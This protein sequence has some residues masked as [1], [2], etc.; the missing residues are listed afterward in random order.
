MRAKEKGINSHAALEIKKERSIRLLMLSFSTA[1][2][3]NTK[4][5]QHPVSCISVM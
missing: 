2:I 1:N 5:I 4:M 3:I